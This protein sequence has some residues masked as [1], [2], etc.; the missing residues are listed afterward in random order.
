MYVSKYLIQYMD[1]K[2]FNSGNQ[3]KAALFV[4]R[5][6]VVVVVRRLA[7]YVM[8]VRPGAVA[9]DHRSFSFIR[10]RSVVAACIDGY[11]CVWCVVLHSH[12]DRVTV[13]YVR[14]T[15]YILLRYSID[16][17]SLLEHPCM[18]SL[19]VVLHHPASKFRSDDDDVCLVC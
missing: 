3:I 1:V 2:E 9:L 10:S 4:T 14:V 18:R 11:I 7:R 19:Q 5:T 15:H 12:T 16:P 6:Y 17:F 8:R 13:T